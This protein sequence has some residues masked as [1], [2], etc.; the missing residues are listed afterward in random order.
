M[1]QKCA[2]ADQEEV[3][4]RVQL[5]DLSEFPLPDDALVVV[6]SNLLDNA[7][8]ACKQ[9]KNPDSRFILVKAQM[10]ADDSILYIENSVAKPVK[11]SD[12]HIATTKKD[13]LQHGYG[14]QNVISVVNSFGGTYAMQ[15]E[16][17]KFS[18]VIAFNQ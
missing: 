15:C 18:F 8:D 4:F 17:L 7:L 2:V 9:I 3:K 13:A 11:I 10:S 12:G 5:D 6:L 16:G 1:N 14:L